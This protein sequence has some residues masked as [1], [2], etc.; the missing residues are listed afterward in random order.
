MRACRATIAGRGSCLIIGG[1]VAA[2]GDTERRQSWAIASQRRRARTAACGKGRE[3]SSSDVRG[4]PT[5]EGVSTFPALW[6]YDGGA[7]Q[8]QSSVR[9]PRGAEA[10]CIVMVA[11]SMRTEL[12]KRGRVHPRHHLPELTWVYQRTSDGKTNLRVR[13]ARHCSFGNKNAA[14]CVRHR[15]QL[16]WADDQL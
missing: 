11:M 1:W 3:A 9:S 4:E 13:G 16:Q 7:S 5:D 8:S 14:G 12:D 15:F 2:Q 10:G 6:A